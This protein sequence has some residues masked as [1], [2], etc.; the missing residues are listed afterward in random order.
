[1]CIL[2]GKT[3]SFQPRSRSSVKVKHQG[4]IVKKYAVVGDISV[5]KAESARMTAVL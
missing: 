2:C 3:F 4:H 5:S 1:M